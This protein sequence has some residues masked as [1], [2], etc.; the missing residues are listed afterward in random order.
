MS[1]NS[2]KLM[3]SGVGVLLFLLIVAAAF[4][5]I[6]AE[7]RSS[8]AADGAKDN[9]WQI[10]S[11]KY[12]SS[13]LTSE[14]LDSSQL[15]GHNFAESDDGR[16]RV[17]KSVE[18]TGTE[19]EFTMHL[20]ID[21]C[22]VSTCVTD[23]SAYFE[24]AEYM[25]TSSNN[26][27]SES[28]GTVFTNPTG[29]MKVKVSGKSSTGSNSGTFDIEDPEGNLLARNVELY[30][31]QSNNITIMMKL[32][33]TQY[34]LLGISVKT[35]NHNTMRLSEEAYGLIKNA[36]SG[37]ATES[38]P[39]T[40]EVVSDVM[41]DSVEYLENSAS[42]DGGE[43]KYDALNRSLTWNPSQSASY[44]KVDLDPEI[45][46]ERGQDGAVA[47]VTVT[48]RSWY[49]G[50]SKLS[51]KVRLNT[52]SDDF[53]SS[54]DPNQVTNACMTNEKATLAYTYSAGDGL[55]TL[56][57]SI[58]FPKP[59]VK[60]VLY[61]LR[62]KKTDDSGNPL[63]GATFR[64]LR[65]WTDSFG[66]THSD[67]VSD[68]FV[69]DDDGFVTATSLPWG[70]Y[71]L[72][73]ISAPPGYTMRED[74][75]DRCVSFDLC[76]TSDLSALTAS[77]LVEAASHHAMSKDQVPSIANERV[78]TDVTLLKVDVIDT[79]KSIAAARFAVYRDNGDGAFSDS[80]D[81][82]AD[83]FV[84]EVETAADGKAVI[85]QLTAGVY[86]LRETYAPAGYELSSNTYRLDVY[87]V[88]GVAGGADDNMIRFGDATSATVQAPDTPNTVTIADKP[89]PLL[90]ST[91]GSGSAWLIVLLGISL[92][93]LG[94]ALSV[95][96]TLRV[97]RKTGTIRNL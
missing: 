47:K 49:Y 28:L 41:G 65:T 26:L 73:E 51:Y 21:A 38:A 93:V 71:T 35:G 88:E 87:G 27:H 9:A 13:H 24:N 17:T 57:G 52:Q 42:P 34:V 22:A 53:S 85:P 29:N 43:A 78:K 55:D 44:K 64:L 94:V 8:L 72:E 15:A 5:T 18:A 56:S 50:I 68:S 69:S 31:S 48:T 61:D 92:V 66:A 19:D 59:Q 90:P 37:Q 95:L 6:A 33:D 96:N 80:A 40:L 45:T 3:S 76:Y 11:G 39:P 84:C 7:P 74:A 32:N 83:N 58:D 91:D 75:G 82:V 16:V 89:I 81:I 36:I 97:H 63:S 12:D 30:W 46:E 2:R 77:T 20:S 86:Y 62:V 67:V 70:A 25:A 14:G 4:A 79:S 10:V 23:Y 60:G 1:L 54:Y